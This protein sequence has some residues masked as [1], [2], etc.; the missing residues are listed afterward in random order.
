MVVLIA[1]FS[2]MEKYCTPEFVFKKVYTL[3]NY[4]VFIIMVLISW[5]VVI[6]YALKGYR[7]LGMS[8]MYITVSLLFVVFTLLMNSIS[9]TV[10]IYFDRKR[11]YVKEGNKDYEAHLKSDIQGFYSY[12][13]DEQD[14]SMV[15]FKF[16]LKSGKNISL[17]DGNISEKK[18][19]EKALMLKTFLV[20]AKRQLEFTA[21]RRNRWYAFLRIG[22]Y[23]YSKTPETETHLT[24]EADSV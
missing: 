6:L 13:Y 15:S 7:Y 11:M 2:Q 18:N 8:G 21:I 12:H 10:F 3:P 22:Y 5:P 19:P 1:S 16:I 17:S 23:W 4:L 20:T 24:K 14:K 9:K